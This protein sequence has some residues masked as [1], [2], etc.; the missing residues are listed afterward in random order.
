[1]AQNVFLTSKYFNLLNKSDSTFKIPAKTISHKRKRSLISNFSLNKD[2]CFMD[3]NRNVS[4]SKSE[5]PEKWQGTRRDE[6]STA[7]SSQREVEVMF[8]L[9]LSADDLRHV[10]A[11]RHRHALGHVLALLGTRLLEN[12]WRC[13]LQWVGIVGSSGASPCAASWASGRTLQPEHRQL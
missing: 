13:G 8:V 6:P 5:G 7:F 3:T 10:L 12:A 2:E 4:T 9:T 1:M 11:A